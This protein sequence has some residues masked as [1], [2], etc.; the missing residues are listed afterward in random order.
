MTNQIP[1]P[2]DSPADTSPIHTVVLVGH[3]SIDKASLNGALSDALPGIE[4]ASA[5]DTASLKTYAHPQA[6]LLVNRVLDGRFD[7]GCGIELI[8]QLNSRDTPPRAMLISNYY[9]AQANAIAAGALPGFGKSEM[10]SPETAAILR[11]SVSLTD[12]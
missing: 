8:E 9:D 6:L 4:I 2:Q 5:N 1:Q 11:A 7:T 10:H 12:V 3:C